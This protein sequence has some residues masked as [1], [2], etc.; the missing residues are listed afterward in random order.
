[1]KLAEKVGKAQAHKIVEDASKK[2]LAQKRGL[3]DILLA[4]ADVTGT[5]KA[6]E[7]EKLFDPMGY[8]GVAQIFIDRLLAAAKTRK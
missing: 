5:I 4:D 8:A 6:A 3:K 7:I 1:M 2:A